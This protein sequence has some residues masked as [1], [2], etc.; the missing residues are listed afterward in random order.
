MGVLQYNIDFEIMGM[1]ITLVMA[2]YFRM[3]YVARVRSDMAFLKMLYCT[4]AAQTFD[5]IS[6]YTISL[7][8]PELNILNYILTTGYFFSAFATAVSFE[9]YI[10][11][12]IPEVV[13]N[14][15]YELIRKSLIV[16][17]CIYGLLNVFTKLSFYFEPDGSYHHGSLYFAGYIFPALFMMSALFFILYYRK[18]FTCKQWISSVSFIFIVFIAMVL[19]ATVLPNVYL[20]Y[21]LVSVSLLMILFTLETPDYRKLV[22][23]LNELEQAKQEAWRAN[24]VKSDFL[25][26]MSHEIRTPINAVLGFDEM[27]LRESTDSQILSY[28]ANIKSSGHTLLSL[29][30]DILDLSKIEAGKMEIVNEEYDMVPMLNNL[31]QMILPRAASKELVLNYDIDSNLPCRLY[32]DDV[33]ISQVLTNLL[34]NAVKYTPKGSVTLTLRLE[35]KDDNNILIYFAVS[36]T[37]IGIKDEHRQKL[38]TEFERIEENKTHHIEGTGLGLPITMKCLTLMDSKLEVDSTYGEGSTFYFRLSQK[39]V[40]ASPIGNF[41]DALKNVMKQIEVFKDEFTAKDAHILVVDDVEMNLKVFTG[42]LKKSLIQIDTAK[43]GATA[44]EMIRSNSYDCVFLD[45]QMPEMDG[46]ET[47]HALKD[48]PS[49]PLHATPVVALTANAIAGAR[50]MYLGHGFS[51]YLTKPIDGWELSKMLRKWLPDEKICPVDLDQPESAEVT[52]DNT[53]CLENIFKTLEAGGIDVK[54][55]LSYAMD[56]QDFYLELLQDYASNMDKTKSELMNYFEHKD[57]RKYNI[58][59]HSLKS[60]SKTIGA[61]ALS[62]TAKMLEDASKSS[63]EAYI[64]SNHDIALSQYQNVVKTINNALTN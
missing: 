59:I 21:G 7:V 35:Q 6:G 15:T 13:R 43:S 46:I 37:G 61:T 49:N 11:S 24:Q 54:T 18:K 58:R 33:R 5:M 51:D 1:M 45:H 28:A 20:T 31:I 40:D 3:N 2:I 12:Y 39:I 50:E 41:D 56:E 8:K 47:L 55:G 52:P 44:I 23:T 53:T 19:Q 27:I 38:F 30:N 10:S 25:A 29:I 14:K 36:D 62:D 22:Q 34:T 57:W 32:G 4:L 48:D 42:L 60:Q 17:Y 63:D 9:R 64:L 16:I 26:N